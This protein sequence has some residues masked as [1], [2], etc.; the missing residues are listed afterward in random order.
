MLKSYLHLLVFLI[1]LGALLFWNVW[2]GTIFC[3]LLAIYSFYRLIKSEGA[4][5]Y[6]Y[7]VLMKN[8]SN[9]SGN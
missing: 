9:K 5:L 1:I 4:D 2:L 3:V 6:A 7:V 8:K